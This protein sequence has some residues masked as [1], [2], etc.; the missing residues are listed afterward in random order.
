MK[1]YVRTTG[2]R[3]FDYHSELP[4]YECLVDTEHKPNESFIE[5][6]IMISEKDDVV[7]LE[8][9]LQLCKDFKNKIE[10]VISEHPDMVINFFTYPEKYFTTHITSDFLYNQC[11]YYPKGVGKRIAEKM[12]EL[13]KIFNNKTGYDVIECKAMKELGIPHLVYRPCLVQHLDM[14]S[15]ILNAYFNR[16]TIYFED[17]LNEA[18]IKYEDAYSDENRK[19]LLKF[20][21]NNK[22]WR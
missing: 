17:Y 7:L 6:L 10:Q 3:S 2:E 22:V 19:K 16:T 11:T 21:N 18:G 1:Y 20:L 15:L 4:E 5:Q 12:R 13:Y 9:D 8:D 14:K